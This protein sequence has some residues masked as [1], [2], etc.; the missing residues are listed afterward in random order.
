MG[1]TDLLTYMLD[2]ITSG[3]VTGPRYLLD[4]ASILTWVEERLEN[5]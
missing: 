1:M 4:P 5:E 3:G 2:R